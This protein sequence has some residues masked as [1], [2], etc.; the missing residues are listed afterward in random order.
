MECVFDYSFSPFFLVSAEGLYRVKG[1]LQTSANTMTD[2][3]DY[4]GGTI[5]EREIAIMAQYHTNYKENRNFLYK[6]FQPKSKGVLLYEENGEK[7]EIDD[8]AE[9]IEVG[10]KGIVRDITLDLV[11]PN[12]FF[13]DKNYRVAVMQGVIG[14]FEFSHEFLDAGEELGCKVHEQIKEIDNRS[15]IDKIGME[16]VI[17][18]LSF[19]VNP[20][21]TK[22][23]TR[24][25]I[26]VDLKLIA[27][28]ILKIRTGTNEKGAVLMRN[29]EEINVNAAITPESEFIQ[30]EIGK[31]MLQYA[32]LAGKDNM[33]IEIRYIQ[34]YIGV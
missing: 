25:H 34:K 18:A 31:N 30:L 33:N 8:I 14:M 3:S 17:E 9:N 19:V 27:G 22:V 32:A 7:R 23:S 20:R 12:P 29:G 1:A 4:M 5:E 21:I 6:M 24:E 26:E 28:D 10:E 11:C 13:R 15:S 2:G 16:I